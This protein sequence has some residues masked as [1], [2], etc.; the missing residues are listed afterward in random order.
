M[1]TRLRTLL[2][3]SSG[4]LFALLCASSTSTSTSVVD[5]SEHDV[6]VLLKALR[7]HVPKS[8]L[9]AAKAELSESLRALKSRELLVEEDAERRT[10]PQRPENDVEEIPEQGHSKLT[11][12]L[13]AV[14]FFA[15]WLGC[16]Y[17]MA[18]DAIN[19]KCL[20]ERFGWDL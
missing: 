3:M 7:K 14:V 12:T 16:L 2:A 19:Y 10:P 17:V 20:R 15:C 8:E 18:T 1:S 5:D 9:A 6:R 4:L 11:L 13:G